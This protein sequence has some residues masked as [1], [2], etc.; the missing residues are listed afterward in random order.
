MNPYKQV[1]KKLLGEDVIIHRANAADLAGKVKVVDEDVCV[2]ASEGSRP[3][4]VQDTFV[5]YTDIRGV[6]TED[7]DYDLIG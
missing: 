2:I 5:A 6:S 3:D 1:L 4:S 7:W